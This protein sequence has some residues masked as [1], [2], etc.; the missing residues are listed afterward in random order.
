MFKK[1]EV[2]CYKCNTVF[3]DLDQ[4]I[5]TYEDKFFCS[6]ICRR[7]YFLT[8]YKYK[9]GDIVYHKANN[10]LKMVII[11]NNFNNLLNNDLLSYDVRWF[12]ENKQNNTTIAN[13]VGGNGLLFGGDSSI[14]IDKKS[15]VFISQSFYE[16]ELELWKE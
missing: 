9:I 16:E 13:S 3:K 10:Q 14:Q 7:T 8:L 11:G 5:H 12:Y 4:F 2:K 6:N 15:N 1:K